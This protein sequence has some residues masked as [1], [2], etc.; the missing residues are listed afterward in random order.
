MGAVGSQ[1]AR[2]PRKTTSYPGASMASEEGRDLRLV[3]TQREGRGK[4]SL[5]KWLHSGSQ[6]QGEQPRQIQPGEVEEG[7]DGNQKIDRK[8]GNRDQWRHK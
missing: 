5:E 8:E 3:R 4:T 1:S 6:A 7:K 2:K